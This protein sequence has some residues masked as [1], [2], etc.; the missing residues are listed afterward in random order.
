MLPILAICGATLVL[1]IVSAHKANN[2]QERLELRFA[3]LSKEKL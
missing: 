1:A 3:T 2:E